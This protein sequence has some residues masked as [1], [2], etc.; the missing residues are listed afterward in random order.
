MVVPSYDPGQT[1]S[2][3]RRVSNRAV[4]C[5]MSWFSG[6]RPSDPTQ[7]TTLIGG[8]ETPRVPNPGTHVILRVLLG[9]RTV[10][11]STASAPRGILQGSYSRGVVGGGCGKHSPQ[12]LDYPGQAEGSLVAV[13]HNQEEQQDITTYSAV[14]GPQPWRS[15][16]AAPY[17]VTHTT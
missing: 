12:R 3:G 9:D 2:L 15:L 7:G 6:S 13:L 10:S 11:P 1:S 14:V 17:Y 16:L 4:D 8:S 5:T